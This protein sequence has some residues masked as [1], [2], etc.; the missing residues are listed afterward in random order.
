MIGPG[1]SLGAVDKLHLTVDGGGGMG[2]NVGRHRLGAAHGKSCRMGRHAK[3]RIA[4]MDR[5]LTIFRVIFPARPWCKPATRRE[6]GGEPAAACSQCR[7]ANRFALR[8]IFRLGRY[9]PR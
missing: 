7:S 2:G 6:A 8:G 1:Y 9:P 4:R 5:S 3:A